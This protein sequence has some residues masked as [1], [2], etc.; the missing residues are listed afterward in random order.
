MKFKEILFQKQFW[1]YKKLTF[2]KEFL[3]KKTKTMKTTPR[4]NTCS[5]KSSGTLKRK[6]STLKLSTRKTGKPKSNR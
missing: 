6:R 2:S 5:R 1:D 3:A 4:K